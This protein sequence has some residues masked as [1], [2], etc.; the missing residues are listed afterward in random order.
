MLG[1]LLLRFYVFMK[2]QKR[3]FYVFYL[4]SHVFSNC[5]YK[6]LSL[7]SFLLLSYRFVSYPHSLGAGLKMDHRTYW[8][9]LSVT[10]TVTVCL[11]KPKFHYADF[12]ETSP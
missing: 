7:L 12:P 3:D 4:A 2:I 11:L 8:S 5:G 6:S 1:L 9:K 10:R